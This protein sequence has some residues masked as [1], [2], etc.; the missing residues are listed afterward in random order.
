MHGNRISI[1]INGIFSFSRLF[2]VVKLLHKVRLFF[3]SDCFAIVDNWIDWVTLKS[4][5]FAFSLHFLISIQ[6]YNKMNHSNGIYFVK[7]MHQ[8]VILSEN[9]SA[10]L[11]K[12][13]KFQFKFQLKNKIHRF[14]TSKRLLQIFSSFSS[15][16]IVVYMWWMRRMFRF[17]LK[18]NYSLYFVL[19]HVL[20]TV[21]MC[22]EIRESKKP[23]N[24]VGNW[25]FTDSNGIE[26]SFW[27]K[28]N[29]MI[30]VCHEITSNGFKFVELDWIGLNW[31]E[32][33]KGA[34]RTKPNVKM[35]D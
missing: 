32:K 13:N 6:F 5:R 28:W 22:I 25:M 34:F 29:K 31:I 35:F 24:F 15:N 7:F 23:M 9:L 19:K 11:L 33:A 2:V 12:A 14:S 27:E 3:S 17:Y 21:Y 30:R 1:D 20:C 18:F 16:E 8:N 10:R 4:V 26:N